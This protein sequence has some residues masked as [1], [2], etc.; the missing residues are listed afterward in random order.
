MRNIVV[1]VPLVVII[2]LTGCSEKFEPRPLDLNQPVRGW[3]ILSD[4]RNDGLTVIEASAAYDINHLQISHHVIHDLR[5]VRDDDRRELAR[6]FTRAAHEIGIQEVVLWDRSLYDL[7][8][9]PDHFKT[10]PGGTIDLDNPHFWDWF[11]DDYREMLDMVPEIQG[12]ILTFIE[13]GARAEQQHSEILTTNQEKLAAVVNA[14]SE[15]VI[16]ERGLNLYARTFSYTYEEYDNIVGAIEL[17]TYPEIRLMMK[18]TPHD[19]FLTHPNDFFAGDIP[20]PTIIE[21]DVAGEFNGQGIIANTWPAH[22]LERWIDFLGRDHI[23]GYVART[24][25]YGTTRIIGRPSEINLYALKRYYEDRSTTVDDIYTEFLSERYSTEAIPY[26]RSAFEN[27]YDIVTSVL[28]TLG[29]NTADHSKL[30]HDPYASSYARHVSGKWIDPPLVFIE[31][32]VNKEFH[33]WK[34]IIN[35]IAPSWAKAGGTQ[36]HEIPWVVEEG[37]LQQGEQISEGMLRDILTEKEYGILLVKE[38]IVHIQSAEPYLTDEQYE[39]LYHYFNRTLL[40]AR[41]HR[42]AAASYFG[43]RVYGRGQ[44]FRTQS[45]MRT[46]REGLKE[47]NEVADE[48]KDY[49]VMPPAGQW[50]WI[51]DADMAKRYY[52][53]IVNEGWPRQTRGY[54]NPYGNLKFPM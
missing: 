3:M 12:L 33:Y 19:F 6:E 29:T 26:I 17:F 10:G 31:H 20:R 16:G 47:M 23:I 21:F 40:T 27:A 24:D 32:G 8:Y 4:S 13:T 34:D 38:S 25:R 51:E 5:H 1:S 44:S 54:D 43:F 28:Y 49:P 46:V 36:L 2:L 14:V 52:N 18:E 30:N 45:L 35:Q 15:V 7:D 37:W 50:N 22:I 9:Y 42:A 53:W 48:I 11:K 39:D 41:L